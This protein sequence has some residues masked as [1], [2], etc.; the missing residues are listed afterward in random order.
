MT[1]TE[2]MRVNNKQH[3]PIPLHQE[4]MKEVDKFVYL[5][6]IVSKD[7]GT[8]EDSRSRINKARHAFRTL[9][10]VWSS[11]ALAQH[12]KIRIFNSNVK[13]VLLYGS[14]TWRTT[15]TNTQKLQTFINR[16]LR[17]I[18]NIRWP[19]VISN[20]DLWERTRQAP[21]EQEIKKRKVAEEA[22]RTGLKISMTKTEV[23]R[24]NNKQHA[25]IPLHQENMK[26]V[27]KFVYLGSIVSKDGGTDEDIRSRINKARHAF[28]TL[29][30]VW[31]SSALAQ[32]N[33]IRIFNSNVKSVLLYG[34]ETWRTTKTNTQ[35]LQ[36]FINRCLRNIL[37]IRWPEVISNQDLW[38]R[39]RQ[40]PIEQEIKKRKWGWMG[41]TLR[42][43]SSNTT[44]Q[45]LEWNP[46]ESAKWADQDRPGGGVRT[47][48][49]GR[50]E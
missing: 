16:C 27:D 12:N 32:H 18:L 40:A 38:E 15:K 45:S 8:D 49:P 23:M 2:V 46:R 13:S 22:E 36:T 47:L 21:I 25:P 43:P 34:S 9:R 35:K 14:E 7:G 26:E 29:R 30:S 11:S 4:N 3:A 37:N 41:H 44:R 24:V 5:G 20:Q 6:S 50:L 19:E 1:K 10:S 33:K 31:S 39:T 28:R 48:K 42:K 17:N